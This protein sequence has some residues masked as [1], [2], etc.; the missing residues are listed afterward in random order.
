MQIACSWEGVVEKAHM[1]DYL[2]GAVQKIPNWLIKVTS[3]GKVGTATKS[4]IKSSFGVI[5]FST[6]DAT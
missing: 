4:D 1:T 6:S 5:G 3:L 2:I